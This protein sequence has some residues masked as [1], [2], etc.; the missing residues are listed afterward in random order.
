[1]TK[2]TLPNYDKFP[3]TVVKGFDEA[4]QRGY[5]AIVSEL[6]KHITPS[7]QVITVD[8]SD[9]VRTD[10]II[11][12]LKGLNPTL[13][14][15]SKSIFVETAL[16]NQMM[17]RYVTDDRVFG[18]AYTGKW[19]DFVDPLKLAAAK[20]QVAAANGFVL[21]VGVGAGYIH[22]GDIQ[23]LADMTIWELQMRYRHDQIDNFNAG[24]FDDEMGKKFKRGYFVDWRLSTQRKGEL[25]KTFTYY[26]DTVVKNDPRMLS[27]SAFDQ[28]LLQM[29]QQPFRTVP[30]FDEGLWG[31]TWMKE[32]LGVDD[33]SLINT[34]WGYNCLFP[35]NEVSLTYGTTKINVPGYT[36]CQKYAKQ[37]IGE[38]GYSRFGADYPIRFDFLDTMGGGYLSL[39]VH[40]DTKYFQE[41]FAMP[42]TQDES[43]Y[44]L[45]CA[46][47]NTFMYLGLTDECNREDM[48]RD[49][50][51]AEQGK[52]VFPAEK[53]SNKIA[54]KKHEHYHIPAGTVHCSGE[55]T[56][57]LEISTSP[58]I[59]T[60]KLW[61]WGRVGMDGKPRP[62]NIDRGMDVIQWDKKKEWMETE[63]AFAPV[64]LESGEGWR[65]ERTGMQQYQ[66]IETRRYWQTVKTTHKTNNETQVLNLIQGR[67]ALLESPTGQFAPYIMHFA[68]SIVIPAQIGEYTITPH[69][70]SIN[71]EIGV[72]KAYVRY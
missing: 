64:P 42:F 46:P 53:Y 6:A 65:E 58:C 12:G 41:N 35:E 4:L 52:I 70:E 66:F 8:C 17:Q 43:Y 63:C 44:F 67:E 25:L 10:E 5:P 60:F 19:L 45:D 2:K 32:E 55:N 39:Q 26:L 69:G 16:M 38:K 9:G 34:A 59:F 51:L 24:N 18:I 20:K 61:D 62:I 27:R 40:P 11:N 22:A 1:M 57:V 72:I 13:I 3:S 14:L 54:V 47:E 50:K 36:V 21:I 30:F 68:E 31:G 49:L 37:L 23:L 28:G 15:E 29:M 7:T 71:Q 48:E 33:E 56:M